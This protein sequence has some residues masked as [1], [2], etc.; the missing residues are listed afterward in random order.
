MR[1]PAPRSNAGNRAEVNRN[2]TQVSIP[3]IEPEGEFAA[4]FVARRY[5]IALPFARAIVAL[6]SLGRAFG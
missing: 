2:E 4:L 1:S 5:R 3:S 6:A